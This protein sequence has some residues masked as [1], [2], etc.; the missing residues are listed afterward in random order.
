[1]FAAGKVILADTLDPDSFWHI[2]VGGE[3]AAR[4]WPG[5]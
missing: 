2:Q 4:G 3:I 5:G 1:M